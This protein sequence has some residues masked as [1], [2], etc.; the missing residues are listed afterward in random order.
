MVREEKLRMVSKNGNLEEAKMLIEQG[1]NINEKSKNGWTA[2][3]Y[4][5]KNG[6]LEV[7]KMLLEQGANIN[8]KSKRGW[9]ALM[10]SCFNGHLEI[11]KMLLEQGANINDKEENGNTVLMVTCQERHLKIVKMLIEQGANINEKSKEGWTALMHVCGRGYLEVAKMLV[12]NGANINEVAQD[13]CTALMYACRGEYLEVAK[14]LIEKRADLELTSDKNQTALDIALEVRNTDIAIE[15]IKAGAGI[16]KNVVHFAIDKEEVELLRSLIGRREALNYIVAM[17][18]KKDRKQ[19]LREVQKELRILRQNIDSSSRTSRFG[20]SLLCNAV[21]NKNIDI[22]NIL[23]ANNS[24]RVLDK[25]NKLSELINASDVDKI[26]DKSVNRL[27][28][29]IKLD[30]KG[31]E[32]EL[33]VELINSGNLQKRSNR[34]F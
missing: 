18:V 22:A 16:S 13:G 24:E 26:L 10:F 1:A 6:H 21:S 17:L 14:M 4:A 8:E 2:L 29:K 15:L 23:M 9:S 34:T 5:C 33:I 31:K 11:S 3:M 32:N 28:K 27:H 20:D 12:E 7:T 25:I 30:K 19:M